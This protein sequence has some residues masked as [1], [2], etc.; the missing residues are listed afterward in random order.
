MGCMHATALWHPHVASCEP[1]SASHARVGG[2]GAVRVPGRRTVAGWLFHAV[3][4]GV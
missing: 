4:H 2:L 1:A 3:L